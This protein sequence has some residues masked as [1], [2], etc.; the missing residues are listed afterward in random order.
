MKKKS[1][2]GKL[3]A[4]AVVFMVLVTAGAAYLTWQMK[5]GGF[6]QLAAKK[7][8][9]PAAYTQ[10]ADT[11][12]M[13][14]APQEPDVRETI[15]YTEEELM[16]TANTMGENFGMLTAEGEGEFTTDLY[17]PDPVYVV[18]YANGQVAVNAQKNTLYWVERYDV[19][20]E[21]NRLTSQEVMKKAKEYYATLQLEQEYKNIARQSN[22]EAHV[23]TVVFQKVIGEKIYSDYEAV[24][25]VISA[26]SGEM[27][28]CKIFDMPL[29]EQEGSKITEDAALAAAK[30]EGPEAF[31]NSPNI[32][33]ELTAAAPKSFYEDDESYDYTS[34]LAWKITTTSDTGEKTV[35]YIDA[36]SGEVI[37]VGSY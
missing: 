28:F 37:H 27:Q 6:P 11:E 25:M 14:V 21:E 2:N 18:T 7:Q 29:K 30:A 17:T 24:K 13:E 20:T 12:D 26:Q 8:G 34:C 1:S 22:K 3:I 36:Y 19:K 15:P 31:S 16:K 32:H 10:Q 33:T 4:W 5:Q 9:S 35:F 23:E